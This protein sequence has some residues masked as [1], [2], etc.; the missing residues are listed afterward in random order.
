M[1]L[2]KTRS[3][4]EKLRDAIAKEKRLI[5][6]HDFMPVDSSGRILEKTFF[7]TGETVQVRLTRRGKIEAVYLLKR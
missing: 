3:E 7:E 2:Y 4:A 1:E 6:R 5:R